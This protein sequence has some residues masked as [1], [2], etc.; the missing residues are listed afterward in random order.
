MSIKFCYSPVVEGMLWCN[1]SVYFLIVPCWNSLVFTDS[2][3]T[4]SDIYDSLCDQNKTSETEKEDYS[5]RT[6]NPRRGQEMSGESCSRSSNSTVSTGKNTWEDIDSV[7]GQFFV[8]AS[9]WDCEELI[10]VSVLMPVII[11]Y[12]I[13]FLK[14]SFLYCTCIIFSYFISSGSATTSLIEMEMCGNGF[15]TGTEPQM[16]LLSESFQRSLSVMERSIVVHISQPQLAAYRQLHIPAGELN[17][18]NRNIYLLELAHQPVDSNSGPSSCPS[19]FYYL[20]KVCIQCSNFNS[21][22][23]W[24]HRE[25]RDRGTERWEWGEFCFSNFGSSLGF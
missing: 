11:W 24:Q 22:R 15:N 14:L 21:T 4:V 23:A 20:S 6:V 8:R 3:A 7:S 13:C 19:G 2:V 5:Q 25:T 1:V 10:I 12:P 17:L 16:V 9:V 18:Y